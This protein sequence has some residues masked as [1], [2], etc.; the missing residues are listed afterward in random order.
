MVL[1]AC[2]SPSSLQQVEVPWVLQQ[3]TE[4]KQPLTQPSTS[5]LQTGSSEHVKIDPLQEELKLCLQLHVLQ[6]CADGV[7][8]CMCCLE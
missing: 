6:L 4:L 3:D 1:V 5:R 2:S 7:S 8:S